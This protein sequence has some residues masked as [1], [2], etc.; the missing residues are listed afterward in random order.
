MTIYTD[1]VFLQAVLASP[2]FWSSVGVYMAA[3][4]ALAAAGG[5]LAQG[6]VARLEA[7]PHPQG[8]NSHIWHNKGENA[9]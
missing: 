7:G 2:T 4:L 3:G 8:L 1:R 5:L 6:V 9:Q